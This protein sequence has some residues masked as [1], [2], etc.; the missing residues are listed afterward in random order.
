MNTIDISIPVAQVIDG[1]PEVL[2]ILV[3]LGFTPLANPLMRA[4]LGRTVSI[5]QG[6]QLKGID[7]EV[8]KSHLKWNGYDVVGGEE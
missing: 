7:L 4:T 2:D 8:I 6:A 5:K 3:E 1:H